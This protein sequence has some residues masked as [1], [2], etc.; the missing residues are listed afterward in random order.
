MLSS[1]HCCL[2]LVTHAAL[3]SLEHIHQPLLAQ[4]DIPDTHTPHQPMPAKKD[5]CPSNLPAVAHPPQLPAQPDVCQ[6]QGP[7][8][9]LTIC[10]SPFPRVAQALG[11]ALTCCALGALCPWRQVPPGLSAITPWLSSFSPLAD[12]DTGQGTP[13]YRTAGA[14]FQL[15]LSHPQLDQ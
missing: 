15:L 1:L 14:V 13:Q 8:Q 7:G 9:A 11:L 6:E 4:A 12:A 10:T 2:W 3:P 5:R